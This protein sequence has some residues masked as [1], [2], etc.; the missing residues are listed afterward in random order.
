MFTART[1]TR[2]SPQS[3]QRGFSACVGRFVKRLLFLI[4]CVAAAASLGSGLLFERLDEEIRKYVESQFANH[5]SNFEV[6]IKS[7]R[8]V[9]SSGIEI[10]GL[11][12]KEKSQEIDQSSLVYIDEIYVACDSNLADLATAD[13]QVKQL[14]IRRPR[15]VVVRDD[16]EHWNVESLFPLPKFGEGSPGLRIE[17]A[18]VTIRN[19]TTGQRD[20]FVIHDIDLNVSSTATTP[21]QS[22][23]D[24]HPYPRQYLAEGSFRSDF[25]RQV[26]IRSEW[27]SDGEAWSCQG[28]VHEIAISPE[29][30]KYFPAELKQQVFNGTNLRGRSEL[31]FSAHADVAQDLGFAFSID[32]RIFEGKLEDPRLPIPFEGLQAKIHCDNHRL[33]IDNFVATNGKTE[34]HFDLSCTNYMAD[35]AVQMDA[36]LR[37]LRV[38]EAFFACA[39]PEIALLKEKFNP[40]G[41]IHADVVFDSRDSQSRPNVT[42]QVVDGAFSYHRFPQRMDRVRGKMRYHNG[43]LTTSGLTAMIGEVAVQLN[44]QIENPGTQFTGWFT[45]ASTDFVPFNAEVIAKLEEKPRKIVSALRPHGEVWVKQFRCERRDPSVKKMEKTI[46][47]EIRQ[48]SVNYEKFAYPIRQVQGTLLFEQGAWTFHDLVGQHGIGRITCNGGWSPYADSGGLLTLGFDATQVPLDDELHDALQDSQ[49]LV[50]DRLQPSGVLDHVEIGVTYDSLERKLGLQVTGQKWANSSASRSGAISIHPKQFPFQ[51]TDVTGTVHYRDGKAELVDVQARHGTTKLRAQGSTESIPGGRWETQF[52]ELSVTDLRSDRDLIAA[53]PKALGS[54]VEKLHVTG[55]MHVTGALELSGVADSTA[56][57]SRWDLNV[58]VYDGRMDVGVQLEHIQGGLRLRGS[59]DEQGFRSRAVLDLDSVV[60]KGVQVAPFTGPMWIDDKQVLLGALVPPEN[61]SDVP[62]SLRGS[63][64]HGELMGDAKVSLTD[65]YPFELQ[66]TL[67]D[68]DL[69]AIDRE[70][71]QT[72]RN[73]DGRAYGSIQLK[74]NDTGRRSFH[75]S[76]RLRLRDANL[77]DFP[78]AVS[79]LSLLSIKAPEANA[80]SNVDIDCRLRGENVLFDRFDLLGNAVRFYCRKGWMD[81]H[82]N[83]GLQFYT[84]VGTTRIQLPFINSIL[85]EASRSILEIDV[86]GTVDKPVV[87]PTPLPE[88]DGTLKTLFPELARGPRS[89]ST[90]SQSR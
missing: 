66:F 51:M 77:Y 36:K 65:N 82:R 42:V 62:R 4:L 34:V 6:A 7:A 18:E 85:D 13:L 5:Y 47:L 41:T 29:V 10:R 68:A 48:G 88:L 23:T 45:A 24:F 78:L 1:E 11:T 8:R 3:V 56:V 53:L 60:F 79:L 12:I 37:N 50:W 20:P 87:T 49:R 76:G 32:G 83:L 26:D 70:L 2:R 16:Q 63:V 17:D 43:V 40:T 57:H 74:G 19:P 64:F 30:A 31:V 27:R 9:G 52:R 84:R 39:P 54:A 89:R 33:E 80:F 90:T 38:D 59:N 46:E 15:L 72:P 61:A 44:A 21:S 71:L 35:G 28:K 69:A 22:A 86:T 55:P 75:G 14:T 81:W 58:G 73:I 67:S 25:C